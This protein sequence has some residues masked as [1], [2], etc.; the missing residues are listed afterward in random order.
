MAVGKCC[1]TIGAKDAGRKIHRLYGI[2]IGETKEQFAIELADGSRVRREKQNVA[3]Y[4]QVP[5]NWDLLF[6]NIS[7]FEELPGGDDDGKRTR[8]RPTPVC[9]EE[10][11]V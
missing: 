8:K 6:H 7:K 1:I 4:Q 5:A 9:A 11:D 2:I 10:C 3:I